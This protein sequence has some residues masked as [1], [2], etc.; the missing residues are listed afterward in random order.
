M[1]GVGTG[2]REAF[3]QYR[4]P[5]ETLAGFVG[6]LLDRGVP[7]DRMVLAALGPKVL[8]LAAERTAGAH[9]YLV[10]PEHTRWRGPRSGPGPVLAPEHKVVLDLDPD[11]GPRGRPGEAREPVPRLVNYPTTCA[12]SAS[13]T[14]DFADGGSDR[15]VDAVVAHGTPEQVAARLEEHLRRGRR[16][17]R[18]AGA[19]R[20]RAGRRPGASSRAGAQRAESAG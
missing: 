6:T 11:A 13:P 1:L 2:H 12:G 18:G 10:P 7:A 19:R 5:Y 4:E 3:Q 15:L 9:P 8:R 14:Q 16:P 17:R 20:R